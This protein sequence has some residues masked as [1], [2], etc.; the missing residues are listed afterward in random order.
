MLPTGSAAVTV[1]VLDPITSG[2]FDM[3]QFEPLNV[4]PSNEP[5][6]FDQVTA[7]APLPPVTV[8]VSDMLAAVVVVGGALIVNMI[9]PGAAATV[10]VTVTA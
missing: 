1:M 8:P 2:I 4:V 3:V 7:G 9:G 10:R 6:L 5:M